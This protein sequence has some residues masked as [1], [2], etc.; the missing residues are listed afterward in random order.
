M[1]ID[2]FNNS[3]KKYLRLV[4]P[5]R[6]ENAEGKKVSQKHVLANIGPLSKYDEGKPYYVERL[7]QS[8]RARQ[9][10][11]EG[12]EAYCEQ[13][14]AP[15]KYRFEIIEGEPMCVGCP[16]VYSHMLIERI[17]EELGLRNVF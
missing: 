4:K 6:V 5:V 2:V 17:I 1:F 3:G 13:E 14:P 16:K 8:L 7:R 10:L 15:E 12:L 11:I 9:P